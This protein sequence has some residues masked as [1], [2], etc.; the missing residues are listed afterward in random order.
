[1]SLRCMASIS[2]VNLT[3]QFPA[4][5]LHGRKRT[6]QREKALDILEPLYIFLDNLPTATSLDSKGCFD[7]CVELEPLAI[8]REQHPAHPVNFFKPWSVSKMQSHEK[9]MESELV[10]EWIPRME[11]T[12]KLDDLAKIYLGSGPPKIW[13]WA[14][15][16][17]HRLMWEVVM[18]P[19]MGTEENSETIDLLIGW[20]FS[21]YV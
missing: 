9:N 1:M 12:L 2:L 20:R 17:C 14:M 19:R 8:E 10:Q 15:T 6:E 5:S 13:H 11:R 21:E 18:A 4:L 7:L 16:M 3:A